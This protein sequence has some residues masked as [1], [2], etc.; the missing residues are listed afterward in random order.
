MEDVRNIIYNILN[1]IYNILI[2]ST[3][4]NLGDFG[5]DGRMILKEILE[6]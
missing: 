2:R 4:D 6:K 5:A 1:I 3:I